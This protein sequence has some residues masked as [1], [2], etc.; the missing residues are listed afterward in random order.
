[1]T[2][3][4]DI[5]HSVYTIYYS[6][7]GGMNWTAIASNLPNTTTSYTWTVPTTAT[8]TGKIRIFQLEAGHPLQNSTDNWNL[9]TPVFAVQS[10]SP[11]FSAEKGAGR[12]GLNLTPG[13]LVL[14]LREPSVRDAR[15]E[16]SDLNG[17]V[18]RSISL[19]QAA[20]GGQLVFPTAALPMGRVV[21]RVLENGN[22]AFDQIVVIR[23]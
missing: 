13:F 3:N 14:K 1:M 18:L 19:G 15:A 2:W 21:F 22:S 23:R 8:A 20:A 5:R 17:A 4:M 7:N 10:P 11:V 6:S 12:Y 9:V 16:I